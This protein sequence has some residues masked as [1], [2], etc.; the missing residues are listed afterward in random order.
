MNGPRSVTVTW[1][2]WPLLWTVSAA[3]RQ[4]PVCGGRFGGL[5]AIALSS[6]GL[7]PIGA[8][9][10]A[11]ARDLPGPF[12]PEG[13]FKVPP[14]DFPISAFS[15][16]WRLPRIGIGV[17][18]QMAEQQIRFDDGAAYEQMRSEERRVGKECRSRWSPYH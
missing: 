18:K 9:P 6:S 8:E 2:E 16:K 13:D 11:R 12:V 7:Q 5:D 3:E 15:A 10:T 1:I 14:F 17:G 4:G